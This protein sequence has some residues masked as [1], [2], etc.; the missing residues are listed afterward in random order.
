M[1]RGIQ[2]GNSNKMVLK[3]TANNALIMHSSMIKI[4][5]PL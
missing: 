2:K 3:T 5:V 1:L 4:S